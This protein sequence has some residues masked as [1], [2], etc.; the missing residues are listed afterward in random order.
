MEICSLF[1][2]FFHPTLPQLPYTTGVLCLGWWEGHDKA[3]VCFSFVFLFFME[4]VIDGAGGR[5][6]CPCALW[7]SQGLP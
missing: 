5:Y 7:C 1:C 6:M 4:L 2:F 3:K